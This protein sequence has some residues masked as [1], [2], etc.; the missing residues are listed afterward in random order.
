MVKAMTS[1]EKGEKMAKFP[2][3]PIIPRP[4]PTLE[5]HERAAVKLVEKS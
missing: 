2:L 3:G 4:G 1:L 5:M